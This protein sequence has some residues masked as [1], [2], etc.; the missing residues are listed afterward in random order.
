MRNR[1]VREHIVEDRV[2]I[3][4]FFAGS[5]ALLFCVPILLFSFFALLNRSA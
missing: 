1:W 4:A 2:E 3:F 5:L